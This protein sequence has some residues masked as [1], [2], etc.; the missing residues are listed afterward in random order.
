MISYKLFDFSV[1]CI[2]NVSIRP[3]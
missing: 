2:D 1:L 3:P